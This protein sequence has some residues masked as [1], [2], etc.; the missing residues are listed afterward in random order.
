METN[1]TFKCD[2]CQVAH[3][4]TVMTQPFGGSKLCTECAVQI[5]SDFNSQD[6]G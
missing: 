5:I 4:L 3:P 1:E 6:K 2:A